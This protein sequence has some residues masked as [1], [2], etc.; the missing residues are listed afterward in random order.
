MQ[1][2]IQLKES[3]IPLTIGIQN[4]SS[5]DKYWNP[6]PGNPEYIKPRRVIQ[7]PILSWIPLRGA[8]LG[9]TPLSELLL[10]NL[11][12]ETLGRVGGCQLGDSFGVNFYPILTIEY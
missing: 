1:S 12:Q 8:K 5:T 9:E 6:L 11:N 2:G 3:E 7:N 10:W 4:P